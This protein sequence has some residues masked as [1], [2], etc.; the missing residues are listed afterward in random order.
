MKPKILGKR[1]KVQQFYSVLD[2]PRDIRVLKT[3]SGVP[4]M[5]PTA[6]IAG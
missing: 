5:T 2:G 4:S 3:A 1:A 6:M